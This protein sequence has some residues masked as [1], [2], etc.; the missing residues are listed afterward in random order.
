MLRCQDNI[1]KFKFFIFNILFHLIQEQGSNSNNP[2]L[3][4]GPVCKK[5]PNSKQRR[6]NSVNGPAPP[7]FSS[8]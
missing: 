7:S 2:N 4:A 5:R 8:R 1:F 3:V 6:K